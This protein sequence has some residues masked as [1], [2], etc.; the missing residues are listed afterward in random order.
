MYEKDLQK[1]QGEKEIEKKD[2]EKERKQEKQQEAKEMGLL[3]FT[4][5]MII[6]IICDVFSI[7]LLIG[8]IFSWPFAIAFGIYKLRNGIKKEAAIA[9][10]ALDIIVEGV[11][12]ALPANTLDVVVTYILLNNKIAQK[13]LEIASK[14]GKGSNKTSK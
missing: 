1:K 5:W 9:V 10:T 6:A 4:V 14:K 2:K 8:L 11:F 12:S 7:I 13:G 3:D